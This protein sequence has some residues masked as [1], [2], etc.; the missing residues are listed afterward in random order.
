MRTGWAGNNAQGA[1]VGE[2]YDPFRRVGIYIP[3]GTAPL[4]STALMTITLAKVAG[5]PEIAVCTPPGPD[6]QVNDHLIHA[7]RMAGAWEIYKAGGAQ[8]I[9]AMVARDV[10]RAEAHKACVPQAVGFVRESHSQG[11]VVVFRDEKGHGCI[12]PL[13]E[14]RAIAAKVAGGSSWPTG[15]GVSWAA[16]VQTARS[17]RASRIFMAGLLEEAGR[18]RS[19][20]PKPVPEPR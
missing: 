12:V 16:R 7:C 3:G 11:R 1:A 9:A 2:K 18:E 4:V 15:R 14:A 20:A 8:A 19:V 6:G 10:P 13:K 5:C 17:E